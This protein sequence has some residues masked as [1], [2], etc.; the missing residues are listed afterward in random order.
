MLKI[1][2]KDLA[3]IARKLYE[4]GLVEE[5]EEIRD[6]V[7]DNLNCS[8]CR[9]AYVWRKRKGETVCGNCGETREETFNNFAGPFYKFP[10]E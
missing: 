6:L 8:C 1:E 5:S 10:Y 4:K 2:K 7:T 9:A 3:R